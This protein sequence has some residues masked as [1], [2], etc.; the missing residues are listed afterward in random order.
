VL[1]SA[2]YEAM[3]GHTVDLTRIEHGS[4]AEFAQLLVRC[5]RPSGPAECRFCWK[6]LGGGTN[7]STRAVEVPVDAKA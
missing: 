7:Q 4:P 6:N 2:V 3:T 1:L 5:S